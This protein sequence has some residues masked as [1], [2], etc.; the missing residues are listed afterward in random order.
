[1]GNIKKQNL[2]IT[3]LLLISFFFFLSSSSPSHEFQYSKNHGWSPP[4]N[5]NNN[6]A[7]I[8][9]P[10]YGD[11]HE[12]M[13]KNSEPPYFMKTQTGEGGGQGLM[14][15]TKMKTKKKMKTRTLN[16]KNRESSPDNWSSK[17]TYSAMLPKG[18]VPPSGSSPCHNTYPNSVA[19]FCQLSTTPKLP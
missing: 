7:P 19:F 14:T 2:V 16:L 1:M 15:T 6:V 12:Y 18:F 5:S 11:D 10:L 4:D 17:R 8:V 3:L 9:S 13:I